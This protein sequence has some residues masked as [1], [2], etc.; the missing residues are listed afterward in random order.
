[1]T[2]KYSVAELLRRFEQNWPESNTQENEIILGMIRLND[3]GQEK[4]KISLRPFELTQASFEVL[5]TLRS[6]PHPR[7]LTPTELYKSIL[8]TSGGMTK[9]LKTLEERNLIQRISN[10]KD[11]RSKWVRLTTKGADLAEKS[12]M[13]VAQGDRELLRGSLSEN[14]LTQL[15]NIL[16]SAL[17]KIE[18][19]G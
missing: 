1:M 17:A 12:M 2:Q 9:V 16:L 8:I 3:L 11:K 5:T 4:L 18:T 10:A 7:E 14:E 6:L 19:A 15:R 13:A